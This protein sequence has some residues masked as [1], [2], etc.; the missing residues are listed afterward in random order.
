[1]ATTDTLAFKTTKKVRKEIPFTVDDET[2]HFTAPDATSIVL[3]ILDGGDQ[4]VEM[5]TLKAALDREEK[6]STE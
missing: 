4:N 5:A 2:Y 3:P 6:I 1:M